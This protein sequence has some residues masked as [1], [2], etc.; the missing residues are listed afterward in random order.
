VRR[1]VHSFVLQFA[2]LVLLISTALP[3]SAQEGVFEDS[4]DDPAMPGWQH[5]PNVHVTD[6]FLRIEPGGFASPE[7]TWKSFEMIMQARRTGRGEIALLYG[8]SEAGTSILLYNGSRF[9]L[10]RES[11]GGVTNVG[12]PIPYEIPEGEWFSLILWVA[13]GEQKAFMGDEQVFSAPMD[14]EIQP[15]GIGFEAIGELVFEI[16]RITIIPGGSIEPEPQPQDGE[17]STS[18]S[19][20]PWIRLGGPPGGLG[21]DIR[22]KYDDHDT[23]YVTDA[24]AGVHIST[25][26]GLTWQQSNSGIATTGGASG[27]GIPIFSLTIDPHNP[28]IIWAGT[29]MSGRIYKSLDGGVT[30]EAKDQGVIREHEILLSFRGFTVDPR[31]SDTVYAMGELQRPGNNVWGLNVGGVVYK[32]TNGGDSWTRIWDGQIPSSLAR[33]MWINPEDPDI[34]YVSTGIFDRGAVG[35]GDLLTDIDPFGGVGILK[36]TDGGQTW[37]VIGKENGLDFLYIG[38]LYMHPEDPDV[39]LA[40]AGHVAPELALVEWEKKGHSPMGIY[41]SIDGGETWTQVLAASGEALG[42]AFSAVEICPSSPDIVYAGSDASVYRSDDGGSTWMKTTSEPASWG[43]PGIRA[44]WPIDMQCDPEDTNRVFANNYS[45]GN[46]LSEDGGRTWVNASNGYSGAQMIGVAADPHNPAR[47]FVGGRSGGWYSEDGGLTWQ[48]IRNPGEMTALAGGEVGGVAI[49]PMKPNHILIGTGEYILEWDPAEPVWKTHGYPPGYGPET[50]VIVFAPSDPKI[51]YAGSANH[52]TM[53]HADSY[54][55]GQGV[56]LSRDGGASWNLIS[57]GAFNAAIVTDL[58]VHPENASVLYVA[59]SEGLYLTRDYGGT[60]SKVAGLPTNA[61]VRTIAVDPEKPEILIA[62]VPNQGLYRS[63]DGGGNWR[64]VS[65]GLEPNGNHR[66]ILFDAAHPGVVYT[67]DI[68]SGVYRSEDGGH[69]WEKLN[70]G[71]TNRA[72]TTLSL[73]ADG[74]QLYAATSGGGM[75]RL[76]LNGEPPVSTGATLFGDSEDGPGEGSQ[77]GPEAPLNAETGGQEASDQEEG[78]QTKDGFSLPCP[79]GN[80]PLILVAAGVAASLVYRKKR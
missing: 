36:S 68:V 3:T 37:K 24:N 64:S 49:D 55:S 76:D 44:G 13:Q 51:V 61:P 79:G 11:A 39:L 30:W 27:D 7:G 16:D 66:D 48:G 74:N 63:E 52:N 45:G 50:S 46:F 15:G 40:A 42:Q 18:P 34:L 12:N 31:S 69:T 33:Y 8:M 57:G 6:G 10:Q 41:R 28:D 60:W 19:S 77:D 38:S 80:I 43:P 78:S 72:A 70:E 21:Y 54:E 2:I 14:A 56:L 5:T 32:T 35:E 59:C 17:A 20:I 9:Q 1:S 71:L 67:S 26:D 29:D 53:I 62:G 23:W 73:S 25:D 65:A 75:F 4:F 47:L 58:A 22:Y